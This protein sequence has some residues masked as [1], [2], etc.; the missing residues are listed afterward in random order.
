MVVRVF[1]YWPDL[2]YLILLKLNACKNYTFY[3][4]VCLIVAHLVYACVFE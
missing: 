3:S 2:R 4:I 1:S